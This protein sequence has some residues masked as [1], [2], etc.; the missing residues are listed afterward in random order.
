[1]SI[2][3]SVALDIENI[4]NNIA[5]SVYVDC[6]RDEIVIDGTMT[7]NEFKDIVKAMEEYV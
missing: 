2:T 7:I 4:I 1:M 6:T 3:N 5:Q